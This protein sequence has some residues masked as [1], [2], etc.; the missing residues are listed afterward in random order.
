MCL[1]DVMQLGAECERACASSQC[2]GLVVDV[3]KLLEQIL[4]ETCRNPPWQWVLQWRG[5]LF[6]NASYTS[7]RFI[8]CPEALGA[9]F[10]RAHQVGIARTTDQELLLRSHMC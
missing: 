8:M 3:A 1:V 10:S 6:L 4:Q 5:H 2:S 9:A 7:R